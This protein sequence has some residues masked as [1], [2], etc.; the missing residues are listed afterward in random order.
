LLS[1]RGYATSGRRQQMS[2]QSAL[3]LYLKNCVQFGRS[4]VL[5]IYNHH[6]FLYHSLQNCKIRTATLKAF[7][8]SAAVIP[9]FPYI[10]TTRKQYRVLSRKV[11]TY[12]YMYIYIYTYRVSRNS[13]NNTRGQVKWIKLTIVNK[14]FLFLRKNKINNFCLLL[15]FC[16]DIV[17]EKKIIE[18]QYSAIF[19]N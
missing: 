7:K 6:F 11:Y 17:S 10:L 12:M 16:K 1:R 8:P 13:S 4:R 14:M 2:R 3:N 19:R 9:L 5:S 18:D 15:F